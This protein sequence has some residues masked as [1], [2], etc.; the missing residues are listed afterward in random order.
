[1]KILFISTHNRC[2][3]IICESVA[4]AVGGDTLLGRSAGSEPA[5]EVHPLTLKY[6]RLARFGTEGLCSESWDNYADWHPDVVITVCDRA[7]GESCPLYFG[8]TIKLHWGLADPSAVIGNDHDIEKAFMDTIAIVER[9][10]SRLVEVASR[11]TQEWR[12][13]LES[14]V[15]EA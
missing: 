12:A 15:T 14:L 10:V 4:N 5:D 3:T 11:P 9:R 6:L 2:R 8:D 13:A 7:A 1:M